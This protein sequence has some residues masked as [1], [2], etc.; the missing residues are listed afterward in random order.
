ME[1]LENFDT[2][3]FIEGFR[4]YISEVYI[5]LL[6]LDK[7]SGLHANEV[8]ILCVHLWTHMVRNVLIFGLVRFRVGVVRLCNYF[9]SIY[10]NI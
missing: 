4:M 2:F 8:Y 3:F 9:F 1:K 10:P 7:S 6:E 5:I